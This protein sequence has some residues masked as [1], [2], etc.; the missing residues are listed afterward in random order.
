MNIIAV[1][2]FSLI[3]SVGGLFEGGDQAMEKKSDQTIIIYE[4]G[5]HMQEA[6]QQELVCVNIKWVIEWKSDR[7]NVTG[8][9]KV[10]NQSIEK[11]LQAQSMIFNKF[12]HIQ[13]ISATCQPAGKPGPV[14]T[15]V[16]MVRG[17]DRASSKSLTLNI[18]ANEDLD[19]TFRQ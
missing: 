12:S 1:F 14:E 19:V 9:V 5:R 11:E 17:I 6:I 4:T 13:D 10:S 8:T 15:S 18:R 2:I 16:L 7:K 3:V